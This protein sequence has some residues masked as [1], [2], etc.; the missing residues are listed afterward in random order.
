MA[1]VWII[2]ANN[3]F[4]L[5]QVLQFLSDSYK[6]NTYDYSEKLAL[7]IHIVEPS[8]LQGREERK[9]YKS[10]RQ[11]KTPKSK[12]AYINRLIRGENILVGVISEKDTND[13]V[14]IVRREYDKPFDTYDQETFESILGYAMILFDTI[15][16]IQLLNEN[17]ILNAD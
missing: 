9:L 14:M 8:E 17:D 1:T 10:L 7:S 4:D 11:Q 2:I 6:N 15:I 12:T 16:M 13:V 5:K 3:F